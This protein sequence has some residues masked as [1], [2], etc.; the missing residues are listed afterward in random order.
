MF[1]EIPQNFYN[2]S[3][4]FQSFSEFPEL[5]SNFLKFSQDLEFS[6]SYQN[7]PEEFFKIFIGFQISFEAPRNFLKLPEVVRF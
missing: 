5:P 6:R 7:F 4:I 1:P 3:K 2:S